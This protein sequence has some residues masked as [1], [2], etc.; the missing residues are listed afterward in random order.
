LRLTAQNTVS[1]QCRIR[2]YCQIPDQTQATLTWTYLT[3]LASYGSDDKLTTGTLS[4][5]TLTGNR[6]RF[7]FDIFCDTITPVVLKSY[8]LR[9]DTMNEVLYDYQFDF[10][11]KDYEMELNGDDTTQKAGNVYQILEGWKQDASLIKM[12]VAMPGAGTI[13]DNVLGHI[14]P[15]SLVSLEWNDRTAVVAGNISFKQSAQSMAVY[16]YAL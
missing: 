14:D 6:I 10:S 9:G 3:T 11:L 16:S 12:R 4:G 1:S 2:V 13:F 7:R 15:L 8:E 5:G